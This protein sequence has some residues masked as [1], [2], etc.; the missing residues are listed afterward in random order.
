MS[1]SSRLNALNDI[2]ALRVIAI[3]FIVGL[4]GE[5]KNTSICAFINS[6]TV[7]LTAYLSSFENVSRATFRL[8]LKAFDEG[9]G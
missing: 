8:A 5:P 1:E 7:V 9:H 6:L 4:P 2:L 3:S